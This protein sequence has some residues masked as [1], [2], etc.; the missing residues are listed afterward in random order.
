ML[1][2]GCFRSFSGLLG[3]LRGGSWHVLLLHLFSSRFFHLLLSSFFGLRSG[4]LLSI[5]RR[6]SFSGLLGSL[7]GGGFCILGCILFGFQL[8]ISRSFLLC[9][10]LGS[11]LCLLQRLLLGFFFGISSCHLVG[12]LA[13]FLVSLRHGSLLCERFGLSLSNSIGPLIC[14][15]LPHS[16]M[17]SQS[18]GFQSRLFLRFSFGKLLCKLRSLVKAIF[19]RHI[20]S[21]PRRLVV[22]LACGCDGHF[23]RSERIK[24]PSVLDRGHELQSILC[25]HAKR[26]D[27]FALSFSIGRTVNVNHLAPIGHILQLHLCC[28]L[29][30]GACRCCVRHGGCGFSL[31]FRQ[32]LC[33]CYRAHSSRGRASGICLRRGRSHANLPSGSHGCLRL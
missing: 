10:I 2:L 23:R 4:L 5:H 13:C 33:C 21:L 9:S 24:L 11:C 22:G 32:P 31:G 16:A 25:C 27:S 30:R 15:S 7:R 20:L 1:G 29:D 6:S 14:I 19:L 17:L 8:R 12:F 18:L 28:F 26:T 3:G